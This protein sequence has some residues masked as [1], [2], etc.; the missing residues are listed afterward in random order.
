VYSLLEQ[1]ASQPRVVAEMLVVDCK[2]LAL[3][4]RPGLSKMF[5]HCHGPNLNWNQE[6]RWLQIAFQSFFSDWEGE[7]GVGTEGMLAFWGGMV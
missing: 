2:I 6:L 3:F 5:N 1:A 7:S 4:M